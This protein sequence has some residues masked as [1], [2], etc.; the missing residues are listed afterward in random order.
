MIM[1]CHVHPSRLTRRCHG[2][3]CTGT[4]QSHIILQGK[5]ENGVYWSKLASA[6]PRAFCRTLASTH[7]DAICLLRWAWFIMFL[8]AVASKLNL[9]VLIRLMCCVGFAAASQAY[10]LTHCLVIQ[11][12]TPCQKSMMA[13]VTTRSNLTLLVFT[14]FCFILE[15]PDWRFWLCQDF[16]CRHTI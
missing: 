14:R 9:V 7:D 1:S 12:L 2:R 11:P 15:P 13:R 4:K 10:Q 16:P 6:Y 5:N 3:V 8:V